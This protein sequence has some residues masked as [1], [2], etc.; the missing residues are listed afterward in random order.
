MFRPNCFDFKN[1]LETSMTLKF[2]LL[3]DMAP[4]K[5]LKHRNCSVGGD[6]FGL[7]DSRGHFTQNVHLVVFDYLYMRLFSY[8][9]L[10]R[11]Y[12]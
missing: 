10:S 12:V 9:H 6:A 8:V 7:M 2:R 5:T 4:R 11:V 3:Y 1:A